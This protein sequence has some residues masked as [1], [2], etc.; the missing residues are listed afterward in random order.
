MYSWILTY[1]LLLFFRD[2]KGEN[3][4]LGVSGIFFS[5]EMPWFLIYEKK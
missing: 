4:F 1:F 3:K 2:F 5:F